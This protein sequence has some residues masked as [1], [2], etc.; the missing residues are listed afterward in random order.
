M[1]MKTV[2]SEL[3]V[4]RVLE[5]WRDQDGNLH[6]TIRREIL[7]E[8]LNFGSVKKPLNTDIISF[9]LTVQNKP[10]KKD[11]GNFGDMFKGLFD[12]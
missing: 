12:N 3:E 10:Q 11:F 5:E 1:K 4:K 9:K 7:N 2:D 6:R 8:P